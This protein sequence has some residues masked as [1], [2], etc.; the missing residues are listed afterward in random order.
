MAQLER[1]INNTKFSALNPGRFPKRITLE[2][3]NR[4]NMSCTFCPRRIMK[5]HEGFLDT[6][7]AK[8]L[9]DEIAEN[10]PVALVPFF[11]GE[12]L[13]HPEWLNILSY[14]KHKGLGPI[15]LAT[16]ATLMD[17]IA[18]E[19][20][21]DLGLDFISFSMD[22]SDPD[23]YHRTRRG[24]NYQEVVKNILFL[25]ELKERRGLN[26]PETQVSAVETPAHRPGMAAF[27]AF[28]KP[29]VDRVRIYI[30]HSRDGHA[31]SIAEPLPDFDTRLPCRKVFTDMVIYWDGEVATCNHD[32]ARD[33]SH[34]IGNV[35]DKGIAA[36]WQSDR[37]QAIR[38]AHKKGELSGEPPCDFCDHWKMH[39][40]PEGYLGTIYAEA[41]SKDS[42]KRAIIDN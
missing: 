9:I 24:A 39:Y 32:W 7:L 19:A 18:A 40:L 8:R 31:G 38:E 13:L 3:T 10:L 21:L 41:K 26:L 14:A 37:Y 34:R 12:S 6:Q 2:L 42:E 5:G 25:L 1:D 36:V 17:Q 20:I 29:K 23:I 30:E 27:I 35:K 33:A 4:C 16:N 28:W 11:R 15:Q 22:T